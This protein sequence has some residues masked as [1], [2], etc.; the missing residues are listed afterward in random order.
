MYAGDISGTKSDVDLFRGDVA[1]SRT[2]FLGDKPGYWTATDTVENRLE[3]ELILLETGVR[4]VFT[5]NSSF[6]TIPILE[7]L[8]LTFWLQ[9]SVGI[10]RNY[11]TQKHVQSENVK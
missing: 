1:F 9:K 2:G 4:N 10:F 11:N 3:S 5:E 8:L 7:I 6:P